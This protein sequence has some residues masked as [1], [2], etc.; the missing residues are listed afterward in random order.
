MIQPDFQLNP[1]DHYQTS[2]QARLWRRVH[3]AH[4]PK[5]DLAY[6][7]FYRDFLVDSASR[8][9]GDDLHFVTLGAGSGWKEAMMME[10]V[11]AERFSRVDVIDATQ[12]LV[13]LTK[14]ELRAQGYG[15]PLHG[16]VGNFMDENLWNEVSRRSKVVI[17][18][19]GILPNVDP[20][21]FLKLL[22]NQGPGWIWLSANLGDEGREA[23]LD[24]YA[25]R[26]TEAWL[27]Q[28]FQD[29]GVSA[30]EYGWEW[31]IREMPFG[32]R[33]EAL[34]L[35]RRRVVFPVGGHQME[36][37]AG[38]AVLAFY[39]NR[40]NFE[41]WSHRLEA[42]GFHVEASRNGKNDGLWLGRLP[43][44]DNS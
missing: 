29:R 40:M 6:R 22:R 38:D 8:L 4:S 20:E 44:M 17:C 25:N 30:E 11:P 21:D 31:Q 39:S 42:A 26:E 34:A 36:L 3:D 2:E 7:Q 35:A 12:S 1:S 14:E 10:A 13:D 16:R 33:V 5:L 37:Q 28:F 27:G 15:G 18:G 23:I 32:W 9:S 41:A 24:Q 43:E 19:L